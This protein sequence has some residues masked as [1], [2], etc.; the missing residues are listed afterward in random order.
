[1]CGIVGLWINASSDYQNLDELIRPMISSL[2]HR[3][4]DAD[5]LWVDDKI[6]LAFGHRRLSILDLSSAGSQPMESIR[7]RYI[8]TYN[9]EIYNHDQIRAKID[10]VKLG[11][12]WKGTSDTETILAAIDVYGVKK[13]LDLC[14]GMF[15]MAIWDKHDK[16]L[17]LA[18]DRF[19]EKPLYYFIKNKKIFFASELKALRSNPLYD[20]KI[21]PKSANNFLRNG[22]IDED[23]C[24]DSCVKKVN[25]GEVICFN[26]PTSFP[27]SSFYWSHFDQ[28][29]QKNGTNKLNESFD[30]ASVRIENIMTDTV[31]SHMISDV[32]LGS[33]LSGGIDSSLVT[34]LMQKNS[35]EPINTFTVGFE[36]DIFNE[37]QYAEKISKY[38]GTNHTTFILKESDAIDIIPDLASIYDEPFADYSQIPTLLLSREAKKH[39]SVVLTGD[40][41]DEI[42]GG[43]NRHV[44]APKLWNVA[45]FIPSSIKKFLFPFFSRLN[46]HTNIERSALKSIFNKAGVSPQLLLKL[47]NII[48]ALSISTSYQHLYSNLTCIFDEPNIYLNERYR[49]SNQS[50]I[51]YNFDESLDKSRWTMLMDSLIYLPGDILTKVDRASMSISLETRA[52]LIDRRIAEA[53]A[54]LNIEFLINRRKGKYILRDILSRHLPNSLFERPKQG[55]TIPLD[56]W[57]RKELR[58]WCEDLL[59][60]DKIKK[61]SILEP[62]K[63][64]AL[65]DEHLDHQNNHAAKLW[66]IL[67]L[68]AWLERWQA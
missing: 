25:P 27:V 34:A 66:S 30:E 29:K 63:V 28:I 1:M 7:G 4:P 52:P 36:E 17:F 64:R 33:F 5:G 40:G 10:K 39:V 67:M 13:M 14:S 44:L 43:Y 22:F 47:S 60:V 55:F 37:A 46:N 58:D 65:W 26:D 41:G 56:A 68:Q 20:F 32:P 51:K 6:N 42:F 59:S 23:H 19:G 24:V 62:N 54:S 21:D 3:G 16:K 2:G 9:G 31:R 15:A 11:Y 57:L 35:S 45:N 49:F 38:L 61:Y 48:N 53:A 50:L 18:R 8:I 12:K